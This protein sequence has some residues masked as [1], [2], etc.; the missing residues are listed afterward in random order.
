MFGQGLLSQ[1]R[2]KPCIRVREFNPYRPIQIAIPSGEQYVPEVRGLIERMSIPTYLTSDEI[3]ELK[4]AAT[5]ACLNAIR[6]GSPHGND[7]T[8]GIRVAPDL[9]HVVVEVRDRG[10]GF[11]I[12]QMRRRPLPLGENGRGVKLIDSLVD[13]ADY[14][15]SLWGHT[16]RLLKRSRQIPALT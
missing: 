2:R 7:D 16:V 14:R 11:N 9:D 13:R 10:H 15:H 4:L 6:H 1:T 8:V 5:E 3:A 12:H